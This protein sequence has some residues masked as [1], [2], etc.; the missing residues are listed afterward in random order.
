M[1]KKTLLI[2]APIAVIA[3]LALSRLLP[4]MPNFAPIT[5][6]ALFGA[7]YLDRKWAFIVPI[8]AMLLSD[9]LLLYVNPFGTQLFNFSQLQPITALYHGTLPAVYA[10]FLLS[11]LM[12][13]W[14]KSRKSPVNVVAIAALCS[15]Q[16]FLIT[17]AATWAI[18]SMYPHDLSG[19]LLSYIAGLPFLQ[20]T[21][22]GDLF[23]TCTF[24][25]VYELARAYAR[26]RTNA[27]HSVA[28]VS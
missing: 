14:L 1:N 6:L 10:S 12:G 25:G 8:F 24:F 22:F 19:L 7:V 15:I 13:L 11:G 23:Y 26:Y 18:G 5:A 20:G 16:F 28:I 17:N 9:Y 4:H 27:Q 21:L 3:A 2:L